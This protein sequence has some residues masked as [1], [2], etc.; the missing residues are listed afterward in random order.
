MV[1]VRVRNNARKIL[2]IEIHEFGEIVLGDTNK[3][4][5]S[6]P[7]SRLNRLNYVAA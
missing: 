4:E 1:K 5:I 2:P 6:C 7:R 3:V